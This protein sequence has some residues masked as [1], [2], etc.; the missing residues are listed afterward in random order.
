VAGRER[1]R[2]GAGNRRV[3]DRDREQAI[4][5]GGGLADRSDE[6][7]SAA[8]RGFNEVGLARV[9]VQRLSHL[10]HAGLEHAVA[11]EGIGPDRFEEE[12]LAHQLAGVGGQEAEDGERFG[13]ERQRRVAAP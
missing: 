9:V 11:D 4:A 7:V 12:F 5:V 3:I 8:M 13:R 1:R 2:G 10:A 6:P